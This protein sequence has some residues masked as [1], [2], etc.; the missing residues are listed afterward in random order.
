MEIRLTTLARGAR[1]FQKY[2][3]TFKIINEKESKG[4]ACGS[5]PCIAICNRRALTAVSLVSV[6]VGLIASEK[7]VK[8]RNLLWVPA[9]YVYWLIQM[10][11]AGWAF[12]N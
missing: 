2:L 6:D 7:P 4:K 9:I 5:Q 3:G 1:I 12:L 11:I 10:C 8:L